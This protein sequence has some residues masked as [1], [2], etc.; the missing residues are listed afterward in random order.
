MPYWAIFCNT[1]ILI[2]AKYSHTWVY[3][4]PFTYGMLYD[5]LYRCEAL[6]QINRFYPLI[7]V[8]NWDNYVWTIQF[9]FMHHSTPYQYI[10][11]QIYSVV[12][13]YILEMSLLY[14]IALSEV[15][16]AE[17]QSKSLIRKNIFKI[18]EGVITKCS[19]QISC[20]K[21]LLSPSL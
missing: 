13:H 19:W 6:C 3:C 10:P 12:F 16:T 20:R 4:R 17:M 18:W 11:L 14:F 15:S 2:A 1:L 8:S 5:H 7:Y 21:L 9:Y